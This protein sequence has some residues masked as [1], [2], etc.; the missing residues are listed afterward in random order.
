M[1]P[2]PVTLYLLYVFWVL[3][4]FEPDWFLTAKVGGEFYR[5]PTLLAPAIGLTILQ[6]G[7]RRALYWPLVVF[8][9]MHLAA[10]ALAENAGLPRNSLRFMV[11]MLLLFAA[12][13]SLLDSPSKVVV[14]LKLYL[15]SF[16]WYGLQGMPQ[17]LVAWHPLLAN[18]DS[19]GPLM[20]LSL[21]F[22]HFFASATRSRRWQWFGRVMV[23]LSILGV[24]LSFAR[25]AALAAAA[26]LLHIVIRSPRKAAT[27]GGLALA[28]LLLLPA[29][30]LMI[31][32]DAYIEEMKTISEGKDEGTGRARWV[33]WKLALDVF[34]QSPLYGVGANN[35]GVVASRIATPEQLA[36]AWD[37]PAQLYMIALHNPH[38]QI[39]AE[40]GLIGFALWASMIVGFFRRTQ[41]LQTQQSIARWAQRGGEALN[42][43]AIAWGLEGTMLAFL[44]NSV[45]YNQL[46][47]HWFWS[48]LTIAS[49]LAALVAPA[50]TPPDSRGIAPSE[51]Q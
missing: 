8:V 48:L 40:E 13:M 43:R 4:I 31:P 11:Y 23:P 51:L 47:I 30:A 5:I 42:L 33:L 37:D 41:H 19:Y 27:L 7:D 34:A 38:V 26:V 12:S 28:A 14:V 16:A 21:A 9:L 15:L 20:C 35:F 24:A 22:S 36:G 49:V 17:G 1:N 25:G 6:R 50:P 2:R 46:Y 39:L 10:S 18:E 3:M 29:V 32:L 44:A 45:F